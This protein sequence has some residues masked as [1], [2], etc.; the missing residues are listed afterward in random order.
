MSTTFK[1]DPDSEDA[2]RVMAWLESEEGQR[3]IAESMARAEKAIE[4]NRR[5]RTVTWQELREVIGPP[6]TNP[7]Y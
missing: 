6:G 2:K 3:E 4:E 1:Y 7:L 5:I